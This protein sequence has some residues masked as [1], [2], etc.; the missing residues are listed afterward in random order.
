MSFL[1]LIMIVK[2]KIYPNLP[3]RK[4]LRRVL[5]LLTVIILKRVSESSK[6]NLSTIVNY[7]LTH[8]SL[9]FYG[10]LGGIYPLFFKIRQNSSPL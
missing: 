4:T 9:S 5:G 3:I 8:K 1:K 7:S 6:S 10:G 2:L